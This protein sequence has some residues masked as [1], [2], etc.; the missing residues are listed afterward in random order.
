MTPGKLYK[1]DTNADD[2]VEQLGL[3]NMFRLDVKHMIVP[4]KGNLDSDFS[5]IGG[6]GDDSSSEDSS[7]DISEEPGPVIDTSPNVMDV[8][9][10]ALAEGTSNKDIQWLCNYFNS[11]TPTKKNK[12]TGM[13]EGYNVIFFTLEGFSGYVIDPELTPTLYKLTHEGFVFNNFYTALHYTSTSN[14][15]CQNLLGLYPKNG[16]PITMKRTGVLG[17]DC[18]F[19]LAQQLGRLGYQTLGYHNNGDMYGRAASHSNL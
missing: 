16:N 1:M 2:Q 3:L 15:E 7:G 11:V 19:S 12:Y 4:A 13:F 10:N 9:L 8:D 14:G 6:L 18:Y 5:T 17:T